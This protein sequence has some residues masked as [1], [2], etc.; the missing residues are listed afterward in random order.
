MRRLLRKGLPLSCCTSYLLAGPI[1]NPI[2]LLSTYFAFAGMENT[3]PKVV[4]G[5][6]GLFQMGG[7][8]MLLL[9]A[10]MAFLIAVGTS[11]LVESLYRKY[12]NGL[13]TPLAQPSGL[14][15]VNETEAAPAEKK[16]ARQRINN[17]TETALHDFVDIT[18]FLIIGALI[19]AFTKQLLTNETIEVLSQSYP[20]WS[21][22]LMMILAVVLC[23]CSEADAFVAA[24]FQTMRPAAKLSFL[25]LG[26]M[27]DIKL[28]AMY[29]R[30]FRPR[31]ILTIVIAVVIQ[32]LLYSMLVHFLWEAYSLQFYQTFRPNL[33]PGAP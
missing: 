21:I 32:V 7:P 6:P 10:G 15:L 14:P 5:T 22:G 11:L 2:V 1:I 12:G 19:A 24:S 23:L 20:F 27:V 3:P 29:T 13:L 28:L 17:V 18:V 33:V 8:E 31:L 16:S 26:P 9:R 25:V 30:V 4:D